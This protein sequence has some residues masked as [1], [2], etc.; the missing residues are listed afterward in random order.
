MHGR[1]SEL[2]SESPSYAPFRHGWTPTAQVDRDPT[3]PQ[4]NFSDAL[5]LFPMNLQLAPKVSTQVPCPSRSLCK[6]FVLGANYLKDLFYK[7]KI[8]FMSSHCSRL[9][10]ES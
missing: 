5:S 3:S 4:L 10:N 1:C 6:S 7:W 8:Y 2:G 9:S